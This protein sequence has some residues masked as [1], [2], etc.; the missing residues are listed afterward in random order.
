M[1][2][3]GPFEVIII[4]IVLLL[5]FGANKLPELARGIGKS[6]KEFKKAS[7]DI[8]NE[9]DSSINSSSDQSFVDHN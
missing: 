4:A 6:L 1:G 2:G 3:I 7:S 5:F 8:Q 9:I